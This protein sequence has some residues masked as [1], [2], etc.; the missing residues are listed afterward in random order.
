[1]PPSNFTKPYPNY[2]NTI[3][4]PPPIFTGT[5]SKPKHPI[6]FFPTYCVF[7]LLVLCYMCTL[8][9]DVNVNLFQNDYEYPFKFY[10]R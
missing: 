4:C 8:T 2:L 6:V 5:A 9:P 7:L 10:R 1:M 3:F